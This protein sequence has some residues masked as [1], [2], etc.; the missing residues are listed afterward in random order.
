MAEIARAL[1]TL[2]HAIRLPESTNET[3]RTKLAARIRNRE[4]ALLLVLKK[5]NA[6]SNP[7]AMLAPN[8]LTF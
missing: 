1:A 4:E 7:I 8:I 2:T 5:Y 3:K 6:S